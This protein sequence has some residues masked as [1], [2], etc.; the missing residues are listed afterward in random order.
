MKIGALT[1]EQEQALETCYAEWLKIGLAT[2][3]ANLEAIRP[4][5]ADLYQRCGYAAPTL[6]QC[7]SPREIQLILEQQ[8]SPTRDK[9]ANRIGDDYG[10]PLNNTL[11]QNAKRYLEA[12]VVR[13]I[14]NQLYFQMSTILGDNLDEQLW[15]ML[16]DTCH[17]QIRSWFGGSLDVYWIAGGHFSHFQVCP[18]HTD[19]QIELLEIMTILS[20]NAFW[21]YPTED[22][23][24]VSDRP[25]A[26]QMDAA[27]RLHHTNGPAVS[28]S[29]GWAVWFVHGVRV[30]QQIVE[31]RYTAADIDQQANVEVRRVMIELYGAERYLREAG[32]QLIQ[33]DEYGRLWR[34]KLAGDEPVVMVEVK[35]ST[36]EPDGMFKHYWLR[37]PPTMTT[38]HEAVAWTF[39]LTAETYHPGWE[40]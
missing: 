40:S 31:R 35:N 29:D 25:T 37:V 19:D 23:C 13:Q 9:V 22:M 28:F 10:G 26:I 17:E 16:R 30:D 3:P 34:K 2:G 36:P 1:A 11:E 38:A 18:M 33:Q 15:N 20:K 12:G 27:G 5:I 7:Q 4:V 6:Y 8:A 21:W 14:W 32:A 24:Y 39:G